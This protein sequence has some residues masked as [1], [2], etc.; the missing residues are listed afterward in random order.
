MRRIAQKGSASVAAG[1]LPYRADIDGLRAVAV[2]AVLGF[3]AFP[4]VFPGGFVGVDVFF[5]ISGFLITGIIL[6][7]LQRSTFTLT[8]FYSR[9]ARRIL[10]ALAVVLAACLGFGWLALLPD[11][12]S[13]LG[14]HVASSAAFA[15]NFSLWSEAGGYFSPTA[16]LKPLL[17]LWSLG[18]EEQF[19]LIWPLFLLLLWKRAARIPLLIAILTLE[20]FVIGVILISDDRSAAAFYFPL[21]RFWELGVG[22]L[23]ATMRF[24]PGRHRAYLD[25]QGAVARALPVIGIVLIVSALF[26]FDSKTEF[27]GF[28][29]L[30]P[31]TGALCVLTTNENSWFR[32]EVLS[33]PHLVF[34][35]LIS[36]PLYLWH[37]PV[38]SFETILA[39]GP[40]GI[41]AR[42]AAL[43][44]SFGLAV[45]TWRFVE[46][47]VRGLRPLKVGPALVSGVVALGIA[48]VA[49]YIGSGFSGRFE[50]QARQLREMHR[51]PAVDELCLASF[52]APD[53]I[54][55]CK[56]TGPAAP[57]V[58]FLGDS[59][60]EA[61][62]TGTVS[63][64]GEKVPPMMLLGR[65]GCPPVMNV[66]I[67]GIFETDRQRRSCNELWH[68]FVSYVRDTRP[69]A[70]VVVG[71]AS[72]FFDEP[73]GERVAAFHEGVE[74]LVTSL[75]Q[76][77][78][79]IYIREIP[80]FETKPSCLV[81]PVKLPGANCEAA[82]ERTE[83][84][85]TRSTYDETINRIRDEHPPLLVLD[86]KPFLCGQKICPQATR[87]GQLLYSDEN[88]L[89]TVGGKRLAKVSGL[90]SFIAQ[91]TGTSG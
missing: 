59:Q 24:L 11:E 67:D 57:Q 84:A 75:Q 62:Y 68:A 8:G 26:L 2:L 40:P 36:Y 33:H 3:H 17:H 55:Y 20:S 13:L 89:S 72:R 73:D 39:S 82:I 35:G 83:L 56:R 42:L 31:V 49:V 19:Y 46:L 6:K 48:G 22:C 64:L 16:G 32:R 10:P 7:E 70:V 66:R 87:T 76:H 91:T 71:S 43:V 69:R 80:V 63:T 90:A 51:G 23:L 50:P 41:I 34:I 54:N 28:A 88:H 4:E 58:L 52:R 9:R 77:T 45:L 14:K 74:E 61:V 79:V 37:W 21:A 81:R 1:P 30:L 29:A 44:L 18:I 15:A 65:G 27:P 53:S 86:P 12:F 47:P 5:V 85:A 78:K 38:L 60:A 25:S